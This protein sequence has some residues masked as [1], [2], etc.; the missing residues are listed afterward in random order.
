MIC[1][2]IENFKIL[3]KNENVFFF[4]QKMPEMIGGWKKENWKIGLWILSHLIFWKPPNSFIRI[5]LR[6]YILKEIAMSKIGYGLNLRLQSQQKKKK[7]QQQQSSKPPRPPTFGF[8]D[9]DVESDIAW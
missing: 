2:D 4:F 1:K 3:K 7:Q 5:H 9:N 8:N 6:F